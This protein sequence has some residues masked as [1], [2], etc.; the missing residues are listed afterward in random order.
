MATMKFSVCALLLCVL[1]YAT[2]SSAF[3][4][5]STRC[6]TGLR[7]ADES[8]VAN[9]EAASNKPPVVCP[10]CD[11]CDGSGRYV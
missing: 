7:L 10:D 1:C 3:V 11:L 2:A 8:P 9:N 6:R 5:H 4:T